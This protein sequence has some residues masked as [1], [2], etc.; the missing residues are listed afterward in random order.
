MILDK[1]GLIVMIPTIVFLRKEQ[2]NAL[3]IEPG[4]LTMEI[5]AINT[6]V[7]LKKRVLVVVNS[8]Y[9]YFSFDGARIKQGQTE[10]MG[11]EEK[12]SWD[13]YGKL[14]LLLWSKKKQK[15]LAGLLK[16]QPELVME[17][18]VQ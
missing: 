11:W 2:D 7:V 3:E 6:F 9:Y 14:L 5:P 1:Y 15:P 8:N 4:L 10:I 16:I 12:R 13:S 18:L 17:N